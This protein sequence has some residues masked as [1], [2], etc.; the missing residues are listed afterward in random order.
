MSKNIAPRTRL[1]ELRKAKGL[2]QSEVA[3]RTGYTQ[4][5]VQRHESDRRSLDGAAIDRYAKLYEVLAY[6]IFVEG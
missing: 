5:A 3:N 2:T 4:A 1:R 6:Q